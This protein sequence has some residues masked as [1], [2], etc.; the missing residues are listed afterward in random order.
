MH[1]C[2]VAGAVKEYANVV[3]RACA[4]G[5]RAGA[6]GGDADAIFIVR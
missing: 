6:G 1:E 5:D 3:I 2:I 4:V